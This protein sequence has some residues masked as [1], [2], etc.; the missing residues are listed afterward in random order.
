[1]N[2]IMM[3]VMLVAAALGL[4]GC[5]SAADIA[6]MEDRA[7]A[8]RYG[9][10][11]TLPL[12]DAKPY[13]EELK[14]RS[15]FSEDEWTRIRK[16]EINLGDSKELVAAAWGEPRTTGSVRLAD[17]VRSWWSYDIDTYRPGAHG[18]VYFHG[19]VVAIER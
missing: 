1:M 11:A 15:L 3:V 2:R 19:T 16:R 8:E 12:W 10:L 4:A 18:T 7:L 13:E 6:K 17:G 5:A 14:R 9:N